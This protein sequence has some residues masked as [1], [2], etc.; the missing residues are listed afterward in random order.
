MHERAL[1][2]GRH[3]VIVDD[4]LTTG[5]TAN[6]IARALRGAGAARVYVLTAASVPFRERQ[7][8]A[9]EALKNPADRREFGKIRENPFTFCAKYG[10]IKT[11]RTNFSVPA[12]GTA[13]S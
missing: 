7:R 4:V 2:R 12:R 13:I 9:E 10:I 8:S 6:A 11:I 3:I 1:C 5:S